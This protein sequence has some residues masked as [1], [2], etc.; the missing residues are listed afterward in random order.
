M[1]ITTTN[2]NEWLLSDAQSV[3]EAENS[4]LEWAKSAG[5]IRYTWNKK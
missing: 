2:G 5:K 1:S 3:Y 4:S